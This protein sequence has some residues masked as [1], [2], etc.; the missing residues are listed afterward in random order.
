MREPRTW[1]ISYV[2]CSV[3]MIT[4][5]RDPQPAR[6][7]CATRLPLSLQSS[8]YHHPHF[9]LPTHP[10]ALRNPPGSYRTTKNL[11]YVPLGFGMTLEFLSSHFPVL[12]V[13]VNVAC[14]I[15]RQASFICPLLSQ[16]E[17][18]F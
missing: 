9:V 12:P 6:S 18:S 2:L 10:S 13:A 14:A 5:R 17:K 1:A 7:H 8:K 15:V 3:R 16:A 11:D 4:T